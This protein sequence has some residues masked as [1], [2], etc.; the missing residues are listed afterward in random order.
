MFFFHKLSVWLWFAKK[1]NVFINV[2]LGILDF[3]KITT[4]TTHYT[5]HTYKLKY[6]GNRIIGTHIVY[7]IKL[8]KFVHYIK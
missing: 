7:F 1:N 8:I 4:L 6:Y 3:L 2:S 5:V